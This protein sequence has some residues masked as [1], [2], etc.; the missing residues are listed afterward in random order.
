MKEG[1]PIYKLKRVD[2]TE[3]Q[4]PWR[5]MERRAAHPPWGLQHLCQLFDA[6]AESLRVGD[7]SQAVTPAVV[8]GLHRAAS[9]ISEMPHAAI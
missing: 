1:H 8:D 4:G 6:A 3:H 9:I 5:S 7:D 2:W